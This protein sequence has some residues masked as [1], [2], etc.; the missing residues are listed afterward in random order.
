MKIDIEVLQEAFYKLYE[1][2]ELIKKWI[3]EFWNQLKETAAEYIQWINL[4][5][6]EI[7]IPRQIYE[8]SIKHRIMKPQVLNRKPRLIRART[9]C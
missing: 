3:S 6:K 5:Y 7:E 8:T 1:A 9:N 2:C 4:E